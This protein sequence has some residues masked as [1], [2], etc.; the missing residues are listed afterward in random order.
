M[1]LQSGLETNNGGGSRGYHTEDLGF[2]SGLQPE[3]MGDTYTAAQA[4]FGDAVPQSLHAASR[5]H[6]SQAFWGHTLG[7]RGSKT[8]WLH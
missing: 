3:G 7:G 6:A 5:E 8:T 2:Q 1:G 4:L